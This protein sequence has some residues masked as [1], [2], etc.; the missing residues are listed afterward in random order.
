[1]DFNSIAIIFIGSFL[2]LIFRIFIQN[3]LKINIGFDI[4]NTSIVNFIASFCLGILV[5]LNFNNN[6][7]LLLFYTG[8]LGCFSTFSSFI[9]QLFVLLRK[10]KFIRLFFHYIE[11]IVFSF[12]FFY[13]GYFL[14]IFF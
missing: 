6:D 1:M 11:V 2:G 7:I 14:I 5:A 13:L 10:R 9:F 3:Y 12:L 8:F 4:Q